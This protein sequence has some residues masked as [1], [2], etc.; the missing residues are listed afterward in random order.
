MYIYMIIYKM[1]TFILH[2]IF[3]SIW[4]AHSSLEVSIPSNKHRYPVRQHQE[5]D[6]L[7]AVASES[8]VCS[9]IGVDLLKSGGNAAD[10]VCHYLFDC[11][12]PELMV[13]LA[14]RHSFLRWSYWYWWF[15]IC[16]NVC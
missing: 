3:T 13:L 5:Q 11:T 14:S 10:A 1:H 7:G 9:R 15:P 12:E 4:L 2:L 8:A 16:S 6:Q